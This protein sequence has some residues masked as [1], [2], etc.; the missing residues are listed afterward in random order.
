M[1][2]LPRGD[3]WKKEE[4]KM[5]ILRT[6]RRRGGG[7]VICGKIYAPVTD[8]GLGGFYELFTRCWAILLVRL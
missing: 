1:E 6:F 3:K 4:R 7:Q 8:V 2:I 5:E